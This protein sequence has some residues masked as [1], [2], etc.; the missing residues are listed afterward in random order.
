MA[1]AGGGISARYWSASTR[2]RYFGCQP[3]KLGNACHGRGPPRHVGRISGCY[4]CLV[5]CDICNMYKS[6]KSSSKRIIII[7]SVNLEK[8]EEECYRSREWDSKHSYIYMIFLHYE[9]P[10]F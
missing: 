8:V 6:L 2:I 10:H 3:A 4:L 1:S 9:A 7:E 5:V